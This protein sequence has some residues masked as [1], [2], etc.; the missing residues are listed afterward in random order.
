MSE[1]SP[2]AAHRS[3]DAD[4]DLDTIVARLRTVRDHSLAARQRVG[5]PVKLPSRSALR[6]VVEGLRAAFFPHRLST[7]ELADESVDFFVG[8][9][10]DAALRELRDQAARELRLAAPHHDFEAVAERRATELVRRFAAELP[11]IRAL[12]E[13][14]IQAAFH[15]DAAAR[16]VDEVLAYYPGV[17]AV[18]HHRLAHVLYRLELP[19]VARIVAE[20]AHAQTGIDIHPGASIGDGFFIDHGTGV[21]IGETTTIG[22]RVRIYHGVTLGAAHSAPDE[23][24]ARDHRAVRHPTI[25]DDVVIYAGATV[26]GPIRIGRGSVIG[27]NVCVTHGVGPGSRISQAR[28][29]HEEFG[30]GVGI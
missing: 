6:R 14:D 16:S 30:D 10:L 22:R 1:P 18:T 11:E 26:L 9:T 20:I 2:H 4:W 13:T 17:T 21:V 5:R 24:D 15:G 3:V 7:R 12:L 28:L 27:G 25:E 19:L 8:H 29:R 23:A